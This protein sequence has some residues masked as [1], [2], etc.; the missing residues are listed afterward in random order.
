MALP[1]SLTP[2]ALCYVMTVI[3]TFQLSLPTRF[4]TLS[5]DLFSLRHVFLSLVK[6][7]IGNAGE[8]DMRKSNVNVKYIYMTSLLFQRR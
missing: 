1:P 8:S 6:L 5:K 4:Q 2:R 3:N 7:G